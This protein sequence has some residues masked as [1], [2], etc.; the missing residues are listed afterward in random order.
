MTSLR[1][2][3]PWIAPEVIKSPKSVT[4]KVDVYSFG[5]VMWELWTLREPFEG[6]NYHALL[7][8]IST[9]PEGLRPALPGE[10]WGRGRIEGMRAKLPGG[11]GLAGGEKGQLA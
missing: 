3:L 10:R 9:T 5:I 11:G 7:H 8:L 2:T 4:E 6:I 1:G